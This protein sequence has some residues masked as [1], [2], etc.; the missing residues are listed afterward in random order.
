MAPQSAATERADVGWRE[1]SAAELGSLPHE[2]VAGGGRRAHRRGRGR[3][4]R[5]RAGARASRRE[6]RRAARRPPGRHPRPARARPAPGRRHPDRRLPA[7]TPAGRRTRST[8]WPSSR[9]WSYRA[10]GRRHGRWWGPRPP[11]PGSTASADRL[12]EREMTSLYEEIELPLVP[13]LAAWSKRRPGR[14]LPPGRD[15]GQASRPGRR[16]RATGLR[17]GRRAVHDR[18]AEAAGRGAVR[19][20][21]AARRPQGQDR[22][23]DRRPRAGQDPRHAPDRRRGRALAGADQAAE[24]LPRPAARADRRER[25]PPHHLQP[26]HR[27]HRP[28]GVDPPQPPEH[29]DPHRARAGDPQRVLRRPRLPDCCRPTTPRSSCGSSPTC[30]ASRR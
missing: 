23:L 29:P 12:Q 18:L 6:G 22:V 7:S 19:T 10:G 24:H 27:R 30:R 26:D 15:R 8:T 21:R 17:D 14:R 4:Q 9:A 11:S 1:S 2:V 28:A 20:P 13:V 3:R 16:A 5:R 25:P